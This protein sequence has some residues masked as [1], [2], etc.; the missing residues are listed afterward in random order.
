MRFRGW[1]LCGLLILPA[2]L[3]GSSL[4]MPKGYF[5]KAQSSFWIKAKEKEK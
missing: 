3:S 1:E 4:Q 5:I 2:R